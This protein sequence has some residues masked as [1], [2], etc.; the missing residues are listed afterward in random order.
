MLK[1]LMRSP[2][3][4]PMSEGPPLRVWFVRV[5]I[6]FARHTPI[7]NMGVEQLGGLA[8]LGALL[9]VAPP[10]VVAALWLFFR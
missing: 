6:A 3:A 1:V 5:V 10:V 4:P 7:R 2:D 9:A 8:A